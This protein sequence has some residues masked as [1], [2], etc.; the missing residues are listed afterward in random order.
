[1]RSRPTS[2][3]RFSSCSSWFERVLGSIQAIPDLVERETDLP[4]RDDL[5]EARDLALSVEPMARSRPL[6]R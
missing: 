5:L 1:M 2:T 3:R 4:Q 6:A